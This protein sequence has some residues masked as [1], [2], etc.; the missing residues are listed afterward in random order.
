MKP[1]MSLSTDGLIFIEDEES[2]RLHPYTV[3]G[4][5]HIGFGHKMDPIEIKELV[6]NG[7]ITEED[8]AALLREDVC[9]A[10]DSVNRSVTVPLSQNQ[11]DALVS[12]AFNVGVGAFEGSTLLKVLNLGEYKAAAQQFLRWDHVNGRVVQGLL[13]RRIAEQKRFLH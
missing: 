1:P 10:V 12:F 4:V 7:S 6:P 2:L 5:F 8:A 13:E 3:E 9:I 11:F